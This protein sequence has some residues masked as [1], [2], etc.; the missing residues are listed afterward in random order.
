M[1][2]KDIG[3]I[4]EV[5]AKG[6]R[7][8]VILENEKGQ[9]TALEC[10]PEKIRQM[11]IVLLISAGRAAYQ[12]GSITSPK[13]APR[14]ISTRPLPLTGVGLLPGPSGQSDVLAL[15]IGEVQLGFQLS[16][17]TLRTLGEAMIAASA[18]GSKH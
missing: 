11:V 2:Q 17:D 1:P 7:I 4:C 18:E 13:R 8:T 9:K 10:V 15:S 14:D 16:T 5:S 12:N 3:I 6:D